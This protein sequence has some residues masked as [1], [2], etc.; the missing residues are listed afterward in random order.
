MDE[1]FI[2]LG[3]PR[4][5]TAW[6]SCFLTCGEVFCQ[7]ELSGHYPVEEL[8]DR[9][10]QHFPVCGVC[11]SALSFHWRDIW[12]AFPK[13][14]FALIERDADDCLNSLQKS[15]GLSV[16]AS[17]KIVDQL[18]NDITDMV[19]VLRPKRF[20][21]D[22]LQTED[23]ARRLW[24]YCAPHHPLPPAHLRKMMSLKV[25]VHPKVYA[26]AAAT[27]NSLSVQFGPAWPPA[28]LEP[29]ERGL[30]PVIPK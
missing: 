8:P 20:A 25:T 3:L 2:I 21:F 4:S 15:V 1:H 28:E 14:R 16:E 13:A 12:Y 6:V 22:E 10:R 30:K 7:H 9:I 19:A 18:T 24:N 29:H 26:E 5:M 17:E 23:G 11:D 27:L